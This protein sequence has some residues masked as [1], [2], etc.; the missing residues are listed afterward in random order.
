MEPAFPVGRWMLGETYQL[1]GMHAESISLNEEMLKTDPTSQYALQ[2]AAF[3]YARY[4]RRREAEEIAQR[5]KDLRKTKYVMSYRLASAYA[6][7]GDRDEA[8]AELDGPSLNTIGSCS[9]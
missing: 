1:N 8:F 7:L 2:I 6:A 5:L 9:E 4:G 3:S